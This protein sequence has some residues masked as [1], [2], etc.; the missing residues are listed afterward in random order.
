LK[1]ASRGD[2]CLVVR[3]CRSIKKLESFKPFSN[4]SDL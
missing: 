2:I 3:M 1:E 4:Q